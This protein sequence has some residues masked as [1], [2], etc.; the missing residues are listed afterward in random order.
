[1]FLKFGDKTKSQ[2]V[3]ESGKICEKCSKEIVIINT[4]EK[5]GC[6]DNLFYKKSEKIFTQ[7]NFSANSKE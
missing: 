3:E 5:C 7:K 2:S 6:G 4:K 1:M